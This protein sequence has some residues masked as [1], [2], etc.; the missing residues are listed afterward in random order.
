MAQ[1]RQANNVVGHAGGPNIDVGGKERA[2]EV[3]LESDRSNKVDSANEEERAPTRR[4]GC[5]CVPGARRGGSVQTQ[6][7]RARQRPSTRGVL[8]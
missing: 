8:C 3:F 6:V 1:A 7:H 5:T 2:E 4:R